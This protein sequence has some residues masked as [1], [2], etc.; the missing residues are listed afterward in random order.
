MQATIAVECGNVLGEGCFWD[1]VTETLYWLDVPIPSKL[2]AL[3]PSNNT[4]RSFDMPQM[5]SSMRKW[6]DGLLIA[7]HAGL[8][9][10]DLKSQHMTSVMKP[11]PDLPFNRCNDGATDAQ[12]RFWF[13]TM[14]NNLSPSASDI[15]LVSASG[16]L[17]CLDENLILTHAESGI[18]ISNTVCWSPDSRTMYFCDTMT[19]VINAYDYDLNRGTVS[20][21]REFARFDR[22]VPDGSTVDAEGYLWNARWDG[23]C[24]V[25]FAPDGRVDR[26]V[27]VPAGKVTCCA[28]GGPTLE[29]LYITT[30]RYGMDEAA[31]A[32]EPLAGHLFVCE[33]GVQGLPA[34]P[35]AA[36]LPFGD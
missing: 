36:P 9:H 35:F 6:G 16:S 29:H 23:S 10:F 19:G 27:E 3:T 31:L 22:G 11:E 28:F 2:Y 25:R 5:I 8:Y 15:D 13:G 33:P 7:A 20:G 26:V 32:S 4:T 14:Q 12:G 30:A 1:N 21:K 17:Y 24:V 34:A 18:T